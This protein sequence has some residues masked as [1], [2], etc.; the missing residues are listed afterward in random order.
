MYDNFIVCPFTSRRSLSSS[1]SIGAVTFGVVQFYHGTGVSCC[2][3]H[4]QDIAP[5]R[6]AEFVEIV[7]ETLIE[8]LRCAKQSQRWCPRV[9]SVQNFTPSRDPRR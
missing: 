6:A 9:P 3:N 5:S 4:M 1:S 2:G 8:D 7:V